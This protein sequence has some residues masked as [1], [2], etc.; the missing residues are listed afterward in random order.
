MLFR[1]VL[2]FILLAALWRFLNKVVDMGRRHGLKGPDSGAAAV[3]RPEDRFHSDI[4]DAEFEIL[5]DSPEE[6]PQ[7]DPTDSTP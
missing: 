5:P 6:D 4:A 1:Y 2:F 7:Q 3:P